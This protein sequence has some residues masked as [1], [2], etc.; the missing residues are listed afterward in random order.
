[1]NTGD[2]MRNRSLVLLATVSLALL[3]VSAATAAPATDPSHSLK[4]AAVRPL[5]TG[6]GAITGKVTG[7]TGQPAAG[8]TVTVS[9]DCGGGGSAVTGAAGTYR[10]G[11]LPAGTYTVSFDGGF[12]YLDLSSYDAHTDHEVVANG[13]TTPNVNAQLAWA[14]QIS[15]RI[16]GPGGKALVGVNRSSLSVTKINDNN[17]YG[18]EA[19]RIDK[20]GNYVIGGLTAGSYK[21]K[22]G[23][24]GI[25]A[26]QYYAGKYT[27]ASATP[28]AA[29]AHQI[30]AG[31]NVRLAVGGVIT[32]KVVDAAKKPVPG[33]Y[34]ST[35]TYDG[36]G[37]SSSVKGVYS[38]VGLMPGKVT[39]TVGGTFATLPISKSN[40][41]VTLGKATTVNV[42]E[43]PAGFVSGVVKTGVTPLK[44]IYVSVVGTGGLTVQSSGYSDAK[45][46]YIVGGL[47]P[48]TYTVGF[49][50][51]YFS[52]P[53]LS[54][55]YKG[56]GSSADATKIVVKAAKVTAGINLALTRG[57]SI[58][59]V[60]K[61]IGNTPLSGAQITAFASENSPFHYANSAANGAYSVT[62]LPPGQYVVRFQTCGYNDQYWNNQT[63]Q[64]KANRVVIAGAAAKTGINSRL[65]KS[66]SIAGTVVDPLSHAVSGASVNISTSGGTPVTSAYTNTDGTFLASSLPAGSYKVSVDPP[67]DRSDLDKS[68][69][70]NGAVIV[71]A[72]GQARGGINVSLPGFATLSGKVS[73]AGGAGIELVHVEVYTLDGVLEPNDAFTDA[74]GHYS[75]GKLP[76]G[77]YKVHFTPDASTSFS[78]R[79]YLD[80]TSLQTA[81]SVAVTTS[82]TTTANQQL[83]GPGSIQG[84][85]TASGGAGVSNVHV[86]VYS[87][88][89]VLQPVDTYTDA[90]GAYTLSPLPAGSYKVHF[91]PDGSSG[92]TTDRWYHDAATQGAASAVIVT[93]SAITVAN[94][95]LPGPG[96]IQGTV[97]GASDQPLAN[98]DVTLDDANLTE[99]FTG[100]DGTYSMPGIAPG[101]YTLTF[102]YNFGDV[103]D[104]APVVVSPD[105]TVTVDKKLNVP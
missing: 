94:Q 87:L 80:K 36:Q 99:V 104:T 30:A 64:A 33:A 7:P 40:I 52:S 95:Q 71:L 9:G 17:W 44:Q 15:G 90:Q 5:V 66:G 96:K 82:A 2:P 59:G 89:D 26:G 31:K 35:G 43:S 34:P 32:G 41:V 16:T 39:L 29:V 10:V 84:T 14:A 58:S 68:T 105:G 101:S 93:D 42:T 23:G 81:T 67:F 18:G 60:V 103:T 88:A 72:E 50:S 62:G 69:Y 47:K 100:V 85:V 91:T 79:W 54:S 70:S 28:I 20:A 63:D 92:F 3:N 27:L 6:T 56:K 61:G 25:Y 24:F 102:N 22:F 65:T 1:M 77:S 83:P 51:T 55:W 8:V 86:E 53:Y 11:A 38:I 19:T 74:D 98:I 48:G 4:S 45:G 78:D 37:S 21:V 57:G 12:S 13:G 73:Q 75:I 76:A 46:K 49:D 97:T